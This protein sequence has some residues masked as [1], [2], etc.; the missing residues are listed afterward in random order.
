MVLKN[1][2]RARQKVTP[3]E[4]DPA[5]DAPTGA[6]ETGKS[7]FASAGSER[8]SR[9]DGASRAE[10]GERFELPAALRTPSAALMHISAI[11]AIAGAIGA[12]LLA[13]GGPSERLLAVCM[14]FFFRRH[15]GLAALCRRQGT[16]WGGHCGQGRQDPPPDAALRG[17]GK[18]APGN[19]V[20]PMN[21]TPAS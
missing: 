2:S 15:G 3:S 12:F 8:R 21:A 7:A 14:A 17:T 19:C 1:E 5:S 10:D 6:E 16:R 4:V 18:T 9:A 11:F 13:G 20:S